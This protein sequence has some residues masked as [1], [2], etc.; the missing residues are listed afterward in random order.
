MRSWFPWGQDS[1]ALCRQHFEKH[2]VP[3][4]SE[5]VEEG[6]FPLF[7]RSCTGLLT[8]AVNFLSVAVPILLKKRT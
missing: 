1:E 2:Q 3:S 8:A 7:F 6:P 5:A 4:P